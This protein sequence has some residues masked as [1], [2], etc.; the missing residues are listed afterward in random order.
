MQKRRVKSLSFATERNVV[1]ENLSRNFC[2]RYENSKVSYSII[3][4]L[5]KKASTK[6]K[7]PEDNNYRTKLHLLSSNLIMEQINH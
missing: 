1:L 6:F 2:K 3:I 7:N 5:F 4:G